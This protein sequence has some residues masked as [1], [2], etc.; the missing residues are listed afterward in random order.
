MDN[1]QRVGKLFEFAEEGAEEK[2]NEVDLNGLHKI[3]LEQQQ[4][5]ER[6]EKACFELS[7]G[8]G[9]NAYRILKG[10]DKLD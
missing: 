4:T 5:I 10:W 7:E 9:H 6:L 1:K 3:I 8:E 2:A